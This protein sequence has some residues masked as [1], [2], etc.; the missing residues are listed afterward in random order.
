[1]GLALLGLLALSSAPFGC[2]RPDGAAEGTQPAVTTGTTSPAGA[3]GTATQL[4]G[5]VAR[6][7]EQS[8][9]GEMLASVVRAQRVSPDAAARTLIDEALL[10]EAAIRAGALRDPAV[11]RQLDAARARAVIA[12]RRDAALAQGPI[13]DEELA[14]AMGE[15]WV[16]LDAPEARTVVHAL[17]PKD[18]KD[19]EALASELRTRLLATK[20]QKAF[21]AAAEAFGKEKGVRI[22][23]EAVDAPFSIEG[24]IVQRGAGSTVLDTS[25]SKA[26]FALAKPGDVSEVISTQFGFHVI[27]LLT[28]R[29]EKRASRARKIEVLAPVVVKNRV[30]ASFEAERAQLRMAAKETT[31]ASSA[32]LALPRFVQSPPGAPEAPR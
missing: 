14:A 17:V 30:I 21:L 28:V 27:E 7:G 18:T 2:G 22:I 29:P 31:T 16:D 9:A 4:G 11:V 5:A 23:A 13:T 19:A 10:A 24:R 26:T 6:V 8:I 1:V 25:F 15:E 3:L 12:R 20:D 32:D